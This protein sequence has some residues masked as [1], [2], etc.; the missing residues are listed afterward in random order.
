MDMDQLIRDMI[1]GGAHS[2][3]RPPGMCRREFSRLQ[4]T[5]GAINDSFYHRGRVAFLD[6]SRGRLSDDRT[7]SDLLK[8]GE[9][10]AVLKFL[11]YAT[12]MIAT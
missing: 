6:Q 1:E 8:A 7:V 4:E 2:V 3:S 5:I 11:R 10:E 9:Y 12:E